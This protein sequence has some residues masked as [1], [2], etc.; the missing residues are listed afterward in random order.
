M[1]E[2]E[3][4]RKGHSEKLHSAHGH[5]RSKSRREETERQS[6]ALALCYVEGGQ[7]YSPTEASVVYVAL[8]STVVELLHLARV[9]VQTSPDYSAADKFSADKAAT[10]RLSPDFKLSFNPTF[11][12]SFCSMLFAS[13]RQKHVLYPCIYWTGNMSG[14]SVG[15]LPGAHL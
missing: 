8:C 4:E 7:S 13:V 11:I 14:V 6:S 15:R 3:R 9:K 5:K 1:W 12:P 2:T 10:D